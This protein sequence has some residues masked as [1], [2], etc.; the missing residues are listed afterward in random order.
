MFR[1]LEMGVW[2]CVSIGRV[3]G[4]SLVRNLWEVSGQERGTVYDIQTWVGRSL[5]C[6]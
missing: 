2:H 3:L 1:G 4:E 6:Q 5:I